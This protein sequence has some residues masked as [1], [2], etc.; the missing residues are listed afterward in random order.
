MAKINLAA[1][2]LAIQNLSGQVYGGSFT[3][4]NGRVVSR[5]TPSISGRVITSNLEISQ[6]VR[7]GSVKGPV[8]VNADLAGT[9]A[10]EAAI[11]A[12]LQGKGKIAGRVTIL[13]TAEQAAGTAL[14]NV[15]GKQLSAVRGITGAL[16]TAVNLFV[17]RPSDLA[18]DFSVTRGVVTTQNLTATNPQ[19]RALVHGNLQLPPWTMTMLADI[20]QLPQT[21]KPVMTVNLQGPIDK[22][23]VGIKRRQLPAAESRRTA[24]DQSERQSAAAASARRR[25]SNSRVGRAPRPIRWRRCCSSS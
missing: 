17:G 12:S 9:G 8:S 14:L 21:A 11:V 18:G 2:V 7:T 16:S 4:Q 20:Y 15:L 6:L 5:G 13:G 25:S 23:N 10:S 19:A 24:A 1:G 22:P 3:I